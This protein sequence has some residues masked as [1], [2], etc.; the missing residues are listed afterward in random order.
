MPLGD[1][2]INSSLVERVR[3]RW[4][5]NFT[6]SCTSSSE[7]NRRPR[8]SFFKLPKMWKLQGERSGL[9]GGCWSVSQP[10]LWSLSL[11]RLTVCGWAL[12]CE[13]MIPSDFMT[14]RSTFSHQETNHTSLLF[15]ACLHFQCWTNILYTM[16][17]SRA[18]MKQLRGP[19]RFHYACL[20]PYRWQYRHITTVLPDFARNVFYGGCSF[21][22]NCPL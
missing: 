20:L 21:S 8:M 1:E 12:L 11:T 22:F 13:R 17:T 7:W 4:I 16:L 14:R 18:I 6:H 2:T 3:S 19:V 9:C 5:H 10:N 15:F